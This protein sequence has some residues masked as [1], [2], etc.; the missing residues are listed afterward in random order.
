MCPVGKTKRRTREANDRAD[1]V[2]Q[3]RVSNQ[4]AECLVA[5]SYCEKAIMTE[6]SQATA[7]RRD[8][9]PGVPMAA[10]IIR[11]PRRQ[12]S[13]EWCDQGEIR[14]RER[15]GSLRFTHCGSTVLSTTSNGTAA[16][17]E[18]TAEADV[19]RSKAQTPGNRA[20]G[21]QKC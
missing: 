9:V 3:D 15:H 11:V 12:K 2:G 14:V 19:D 5:S 8:R 18:E 21:I 13:S 4:G 10:G 17:P 7:A 20:G 6:C 16:R 1:R